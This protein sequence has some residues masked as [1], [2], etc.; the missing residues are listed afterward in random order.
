MRV[1]PQKSNNLIYESVALRPYIRIMAKIRFLLF[2]LV[3]TASVTGQVDAQT[4]PETRALLD[5]IAQ[6]EAKVQSLS[7]QIYR[8]QSIDPNAYSGSGVGIAGAAG[9]SAG[10][11]SEL[12]IAELERELRDLTGQVEQAN[13]TAKKAQNDLEKLRSDIDIRFQQNNN[14]KSPAAAAAND[15]TA[16]SAETTEAGDGDQMIISRGDDDTGTTAPAATP[17]PSETPKTTAKLGD[18][19]PKPDKLYDDAYAA[20]RAKDYAKTEMLFRQF[21]QIYPQHSLAGNAQYW[22]GESYYGRADYKSAAGA[23]AEGY[24]KYP[25]GPKAPDSLLKLGLSLSAQNRAA[26]ACVVYRQLVKTYPTAS[27]TIATKAESEIVRL[28]CK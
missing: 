15:K 20:L 11:S 19:K 6:L 22:L 16:T 12:R 4:T 13:F 5:R 17:A 27:G 7:Q 8:T 10:G 23:F 2:L 1:N 26:D 25:K 21:L 28:K 3:V 14:A 9:D 24:Q 18:Q